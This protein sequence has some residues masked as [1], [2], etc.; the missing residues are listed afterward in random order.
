MKSKIRDQNYEIECF[1]GEWLGAGQCPVII[2][3]TKIW[4]IMIFSNDNLTKYNI[5][6]NSDVILVTGYNKSRI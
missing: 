4:F 3:Y 6:D 5:S 2:F 1:E